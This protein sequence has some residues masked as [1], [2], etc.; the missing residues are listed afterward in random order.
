MTIHHVVEIDNK[1]QNV[2][3]V[4]TDQGIIIEVDPVA[5]FTDMVRNLT[6]DKSILDD[7]TDFIREHY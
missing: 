6:G 3:L 5:L 7:M 1:D 2:T 4:T